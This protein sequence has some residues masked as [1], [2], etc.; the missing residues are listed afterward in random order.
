GMAAAESQGVLHLRKDWYASP[1]D[2]L[3]YLGFTRL[4]H[5]LLTCPQPYIE[6]T[7]GS[8]SDENSGCVTVNVAVSGPM[9]T[10]C[11]DLRRVVPLVQQARAARPSEPLNDAI[12]PVLQGMCRGEI[13][14]GMWTRGSGTPA[15]V[16]L[17]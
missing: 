14:G 15:E 11:V 10:F 16:D 2:G 7:Q 1:I 9:S 4:C 5:D 17:M 8:Y 6:G 3:D 12:R 13:P